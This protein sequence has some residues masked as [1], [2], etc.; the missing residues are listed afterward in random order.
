[1]YLHS[2]TGILRRAVGLQGA[3]NGYSGIQ[4]QSRR[5]LQSWEEKEGHPRK[6]ET[7]PRYGRVSNNRLFRA[8]LNMNV[9]TITLW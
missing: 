8:L 6:I 1:M 4:S 7:L 2:K 3:K 9:L 5:L